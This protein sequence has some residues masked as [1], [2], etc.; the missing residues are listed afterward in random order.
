MQ[1]QF[2]KRILGHTFNL[3]EQYFKGSRA[4]FKGE[5]EKLSYSEWP[6]IS[7]IQKFSGMGLFCA[8][9]VK[10]NITKYLLHTYC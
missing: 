5:N 8:K 7:L 3:I 9:T 1:E 4:T 10:A 6:E 2:H